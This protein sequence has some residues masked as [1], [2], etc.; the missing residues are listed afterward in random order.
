MDQLDLGLSGAAFAG[1]H[2][3][4][5]WISRSRSEPPFPGGWSLRPSAGPTSGSSETPIPSNPTGIS[6]DH[7]QPPSNTFHPDDSVRGR[8]SAPRVTRDSQS[9]GSGSDATAFHDS[10]SDKHT[11]FLHD[12]HS[13]TFNGQERYNHPGMYRCLH[14]DAR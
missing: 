14:L 10:S 4:R 13:P 7:L 5:R 9:V 2:Q 12:G 3:A 8:D 11:A 6:S 1:A